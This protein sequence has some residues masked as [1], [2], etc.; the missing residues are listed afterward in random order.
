MSTI[1][2]WMENHNGNWVWVDGSEGVRATVYANH[3]GTWGA[4]WNR[5]LDGMPRQLRA[6]FGCAN[7]AQQAVE[8]ADREGSGSLKWWPRDDEWIESKK[9]GFYRKVHGVIVSVKQAK[10]KSWYAVNMTGALLGEN[11]SPAWR[12]SAED[13]CRAVDEFAA[14]TGHWQWIMRQ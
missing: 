2:K 11:G 5:A 9:G 7:D 4:I 14:R 8:I 13:S 6:K 1:E 3:D 10:S 12:A